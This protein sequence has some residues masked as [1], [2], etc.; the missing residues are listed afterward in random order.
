M[1]QV[2]KCLGYTQFSPAQPVCKGLQ[3]THSCFLAS[4][5][6]ND[7]SQPVGLVVNSV[8]PGVFERNKQCKTEL[9]RQLCILAGSAKSEAFRWTNFSW[10][11][12]SILWEH[13]I[14]K[15]L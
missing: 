7:D 10:T 6:D 9:Q 2:D 12:P 11:G 3:T 8:I 5:Q 4:H 15:R 13:I 1:P 14:W